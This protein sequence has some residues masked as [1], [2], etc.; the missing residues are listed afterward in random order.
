MHFESFES[1]QTTINQR[2]PMAA[3]L[4]KILFDMYTCNNLA[5]VFGEA[6]GK[7]LGWVQLQRYST[8]HMFKSD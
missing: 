8:S 2:L 7:L 4:G 3:K 1:E 5:L 6:N